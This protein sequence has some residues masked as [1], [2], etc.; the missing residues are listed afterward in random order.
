VPNQTG[1]LSRLELQLHHSDA[2]GTSFVA[3]IGLWS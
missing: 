3:E 1:A 2:L